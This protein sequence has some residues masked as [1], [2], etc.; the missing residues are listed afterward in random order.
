MTI[1]RIYTEGK[2]P[3][4]PWK[5]KSP[6]IVMRRGTLTPDSRA[7]E[8][9][10]AAHSWGKASGGGVVVGEARVVVGGEF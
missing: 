10:R 6:F 7:W 1:T 5:S 4:G 8:A 3:S 2:I 9:E